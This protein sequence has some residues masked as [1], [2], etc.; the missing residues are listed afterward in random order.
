MDAGRERTDGGAPAPAGGRGHGRGGRPMTPGRALRAT[1]AAVVLA[2]GLVAAGAGTGPVAAATAT[3]SLTCADGNTGAPLTAT[4]S[5]FTVY[6]E[7]FTNYPSDGNLYPGDGTVALAGIELRSDGASSLVL[8]GWTAS[9]ETV[10]VGGVDAAPAN[11][12][13]TPD[14][15][16]SVVLRPGVDAAT[17][18]R[19]LADA[20]G[21][22]ATDLAYAAGSGTTLTLPANGSFDE[23]RRVRAL[24]ADTGAVVATSTVA[25]DDTVTLALPATSGR[26]VDLVSEAGAYDVTLEG[27]R[28][29]VSADGTVRLTAAV[30]NTGDARATRAVELSV[31]GSVVETRR[32]T[33][34]PGN[35]ERLAFVVPAR[36]LALGEHAATVD[37][38]ADAA[39]AAFDVGRPPNVSVVLD[40]PTAATAG[41]RATLRATFENAGDVDSSALVDLRVDGRVVDT[42]LVGF[43]GRSAESV[44]LSWTPTADAAGTARLRVVPRTSLD[45]TGERTATVT[46]L[47]ASN[48]SYADLV[49]EPST[50]AAGES[51]TATATVTNDGDAAADVAVP[52]LVD[53]A[54]V[55]NRSVTLA[56]GAS[57]TVS[58]APS[59]DAPGTRSVAVGDLPPRSVTVRA[60]DRPTLPG[61][62]GPAGNADGDPALEDVN[63]DGRV[64]AAD[65]TFLFERRDAA[66]VTS[67][68]TAFDFNG[69]GEFSLSDVTALRRGLPD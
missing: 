31:D 67:N 36:S 58:F 15:D 30:T 23:G 14:G 28:S 3:P 32:P 61:A 55:A 29:T 46:V 19:S 4:S 42:E 68:P 22:G 39:T 17:W 47:A 2:V 21:G 6:N 62:A 1:L 45:V 60:V 41:E 64:T 43:A 51:V 11:V 49:V 26:E 50:V 57:T 52:L 48:V 10:C 65:A 54:V 59:L 12:T 44:T 40:P 9:S 63:G 53:G 56:A 16:G 25:A 66:A 34:A 8:E 20:Y 24:D 69:D 7:R 37:T 38:D 18:R 27:P 33:V 13:V 35:T 5:G